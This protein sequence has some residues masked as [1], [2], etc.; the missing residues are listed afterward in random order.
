MRS[1]RLQLN[2][3]KTDVMWCSSARRVS[4]LPSCP[5][6]IA[7]INMQPV[8]T[9][10]SL[11]VLIDND[12]GSSSHVRMVVSRCF[13]A[14]RQ[15]R[16]LRRYVNEDC[17]RSLVAALVHTRLDYGNFVLVGSPA[18]RLRLLQ[19]ILNA[20]ARLIFRL[21][22]FDHITDSLVALHWLRAPERVDYK[23]A[24]LTYRVLHGFAPPYLDVLQRTADL[25]NRRNLRSSILLVGWRSQLIFSPLLVAVCSLLQ[26]RSN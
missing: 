12:L 26:Q 17:F 15:L 23:L 4:T 25:P 18:C 13:A 20:A 22:R 5:I 19:S 16:H 6:S 11:G 8:T 7:G 10:R 2:A 3:D 14:L 1:N 9:V 21:R 24:V